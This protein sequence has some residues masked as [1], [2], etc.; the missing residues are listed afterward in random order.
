MISYILGHE[1]VHYYVCWTLVLDGGEW[2]ASR[3]GRLAS[4]EGVPVAL[5]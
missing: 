1:K 5:A 2:T 4:M 3:F